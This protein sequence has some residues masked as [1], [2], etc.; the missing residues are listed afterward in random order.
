[1]EYGCNKCYN[2]NERTAQTPDQTTLLTRLRGPSFGRPSAD[3]MFDRI[4]FSLSHSHFLSYTRHTNCMYVLQSISLSLTLSLSLFLSLSLPDPSRAPVRSF[5]TLH[6][7]ADRNDFGSRGLIRNTTVYIRIY[8]HTYI[9]VRP[10]TGDTNWPAETV[11]SITRRAFVRRLK[12]PC[13]HSVTL[14]VTPSRLINTYT[15]VARN[16]V[17]GRV[18]PE[19]WSVEKARWVNV[20][21]VNRYVRRR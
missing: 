9:P 10:L 13:R 5:R 19:Q 11:N 7:S 17:C 1:M 14:H 6:T 4:C 16:R 18:P 15:H 3:T 12:S 8:I 20:I 21:V 2:G